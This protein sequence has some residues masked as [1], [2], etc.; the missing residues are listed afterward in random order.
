M[1]NCPKCHE[2]MNE[3]KADE[4]QPYRPRSWSCQA[5]QIVAEARHPAQIVHVAIG[6]EIEEAGQRRR[7]IAKDIIGAE[8]IV[9]WE[10]CAG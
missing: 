3:V 8:L 10:T 1:P 2:P 5:D 4:S 7:V 9:F 6:R